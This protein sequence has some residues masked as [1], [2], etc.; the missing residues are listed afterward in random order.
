[1]R[2]FP[3]SVRL[4]ASDL[5]VFHRAAEPGEW[6]VTGSF[7]FAE[8]DPAGWDSKEQLAFK[9]GWLGCES[10]G[11]TTLV[12]VAEIEEADF[13][14]VVERLARH[15]VE[16]YGAPDLARALPVARAEAEDAASLCGH[17]RHT[18]LALER[19]FGETG[20]VERVKLIEPARAQD[21][22]RIWEVVAD[23]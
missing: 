14:Q 21:H 11:R 12:E 10:F 23:D 1:M 8:G 19:A 18:L 7:A 15:F 13:F 4:D 17:K 16:R 6:A 3:R 22:A 9:S 2:K 5:S 20:I